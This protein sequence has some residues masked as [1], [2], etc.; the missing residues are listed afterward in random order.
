MERSQDPGHERTDDRQPGVLIAYH[1][2]PCSHRAAQRPCSCPALS[3]T[4]LDQRAS[5]VQLYSLLSYTALG[6]WC[7]WSASTYV[8]AQRDYTL[9]RLLLCCSFA[10]GEMMAR[11][12]ML[13]LGRLRLPLLPRHW[14]TLPIFRA[15]MEVGLACDRLLLRLP[16]VIAPVVSYASYATLQ[17][18]KA[19][20][21]QC[22]L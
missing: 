21:L 7:C 6:V 9:L 11:V 13:R 22:P 3:S 15:S 19:M 14:I 1:P 17:S 5:R 20:P 16:P 12:L 4:T 10:F 2:S 18:H 8:G